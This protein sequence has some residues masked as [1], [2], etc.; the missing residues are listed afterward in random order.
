M[1]FEATA[2]KM[3]ADFIARNIE[4]TLSFTKDVWGTLDESIKLKLKTAQS[5]SVIFFIIKY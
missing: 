2:G 1:D 3:A 4:N 5:N